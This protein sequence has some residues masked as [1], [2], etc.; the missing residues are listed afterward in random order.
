MPGSFIDQL[1][2][3]EETEWKAHKSFKYLLEWQAVGKKC[4]TSSFLSFIGEQGPE[5]GPLV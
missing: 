3:G 5:K 2:G 4:L 1:V